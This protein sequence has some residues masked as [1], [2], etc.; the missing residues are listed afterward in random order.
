MAMMWF[1]CDESYDSKKKVSDTYVVGGIVADHITWGLIEKRWQAKNDRARV[2]LFH[3][4]H[5]NAHT[6]EFNG[7]TRQR[8]K[9]YAQSLCKILRDQ[10]RHIQ[11]VS[12]GLLNKEYQ[13]IISD[14]GRKKLGHPYIVCFKECMILIAEE[15][16]RWWKPEDKFSVILEEN[17]FQDEAIKLFNEM[18]KQKQ[19]P[20]HIHLGACAAGAKGEY[21][22]L[23]PADLIAYETFRLIHEKHYGQQKVRK[24]LE[25][26][27]PSN[28]FSGFY[29]DA[30]E[31]EYIKDK[32]ES[33]Q[34]APN[35]FIG[36]HP[37]SYTGP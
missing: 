22:A 30:G 2:P 1:Y 29:Y 13:K 16:G 8:S 14:E 19:W 15:M 10:K 28:G 36:I 11:V 18:K 5:L 31:L 25:K 33:A 3:A 23:Q 7:W 24:A 21:I 27:F 26:L 17:P 34:V 32:V 9:R 6:Y 37:P 35:G 12:V 20:N 4:S